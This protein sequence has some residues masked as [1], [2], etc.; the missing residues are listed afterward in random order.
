MTKT[1]ILTA[2]L[3][4][5]VALPSMTFAG[6]VANGFRDTGCEEA[7]QT[8][9]YGE[10]GNY[11]YSLNPTCPNGQ[12]GMDANH[13]SKLAPAPVVDVPVEEPPVDD[14]EVAEDPVDEPVIDAAKA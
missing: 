6:H 13:P 4:G 7:A 11:L 2:A 1:L 8:R 14:E 9:I 5:G 12:G 3:L 10:D